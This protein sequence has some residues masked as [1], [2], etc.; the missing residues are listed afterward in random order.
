MANATIVALHTPWLSATL[1]KAT[2]TGMVVGSCYGTWLPSSPAHVMRVLL[3]PELGPRGPVSG[4]GR[5]WPEPNGSG[6]RGSAANG[7]GVRVSENA[8]V[9][10]D[11]GTAPH[12]LAMPRH[13]THVIHGVSV[14]YGWR[15]WPCSARVPE[16]L[17][18]S[19]DT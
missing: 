13:C 6:R 8:A 1:A 11:T 2:T 16:M 15:G 17:V 7:S 9:P 14:A 10:A 12:V 19:D 3:L 4:N 5:T 18:G